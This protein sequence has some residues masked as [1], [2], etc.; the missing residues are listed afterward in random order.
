MVGTGTPCPVPCPTPVP[1]GLPAKALLCCNAEASG[2]QRVGERESE[3]GEGRCWPGAAPGLL[4]KPLPSARALPATLAVA[5]L[6]VGTRSSLALERSWGSDSRLSG[7]GGMSARNLRRDVA[8][9]SCPYS[10][11]LGGVLSQ[12]PSAWANGNPI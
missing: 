7:T 2:S 4:A 6:L 1:A 8:G 5:H 9:S 3:P 11:S 10:Q 12:H